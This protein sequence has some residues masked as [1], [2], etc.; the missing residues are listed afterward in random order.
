MPAR[1]RSVRHLFASTKIGKA[2]S[3]EHDGASR[4]IRVNRLSRSALPPCM[5][6]GPLRPAWPLRPPCLVR[7]YRSQLEF[8]RVP[9]PLCLACHCSSHCLD[10]SILA[11]APTCNSLFQS[12]QLIIPISS[13]CTSWR[14]E[15]CRLQL[16]H[17]DDHQAV[18]FWL[19]VESPGFHCSHFLISLF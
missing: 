1:R 3:R 12:L 17:I 11:C 10:L 4:R 19:W 5:S 16:I 7:L 2:F 14:G 18:R 8:E 13:P 6:S 15:F 9:R